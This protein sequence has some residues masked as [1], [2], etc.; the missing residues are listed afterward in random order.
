MI[1]LLI[2]VLTSSNLLA[3]KE[4]IKS[5]ENQKNTKIKYQLVIIVNTLNDSYYEEVKSNIKKKYKIIRTKSN[6]Y[7]G[8]GHN[9][10]LEFFKEEKNN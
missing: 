1:K 2:A 5:I 4:S 7:P 10:V 6:G 9:S 8:K 3:L